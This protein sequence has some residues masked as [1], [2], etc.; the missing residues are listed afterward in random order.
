MPAR[1]DLTMYQG[2]DYAHV[3]TF[4]AADGDPYPLPG[5]VTA[6]IR[7]RHADTAP[8]AILVVDVTGNEV[9]LHLAREVTATLSGGYVWDLEHELDGVVVTFLH[10]TVNVAR[11]VTRV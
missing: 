8:A 3:V 4:V 5:V 10:G 7:R 1:R 2:D 11:E 9:V 6:H